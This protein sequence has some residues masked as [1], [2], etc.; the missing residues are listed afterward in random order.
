[1]TRD[2]VA[3]YITMREIYMD[4]VAR[5]TGESEGS[6]VKKL[7]CWEDGKGCGHQTVLRKL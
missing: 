2:I 1:M 7:G 4:V 5:K 6:L 3:C